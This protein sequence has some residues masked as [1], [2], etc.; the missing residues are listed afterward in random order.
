M[1]MLDDDD[2]DDACMMMHDVYAAKIQL[3]LLENV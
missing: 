1:M 2:D 3:F